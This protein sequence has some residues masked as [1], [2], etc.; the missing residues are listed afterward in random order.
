LQPRYRL[1]DLVPDKEQAVDASHR[2]DS[3]LSGANP[4]DALVE[5]PKGQSL[6]SPDTL[7][8]IAEVQSIV[9]SQ[10][11]I[12]NV[13]SLETLRRWLAK[14]AGGS[15]V[16]TLKQYVDLLPES[17][18]RRFISADQTAVV[19]SGRVA[20]LDASQLLP[21]IDSLNAALN[22]ARSKHPGYKISLTGLSVIAAQNSA[23]MIEKLNHGL[24]VEVLFVA[25]FIGLAFRSVIIS[26]AII[27]P[28]IFPILAAGDILWALGDGLQFASV[29]ALT[30]SF[31]LGLSAT[32]HFLNRLRLE[33]RPDAGPPS[34]SS[35]PRFLLVPL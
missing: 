34:A 10:P 18:V 24:M 31:G 9:E 32:I 17:L 8:T 20:D 5:I 27:L 4:I 29:V 23:A 7:A 6:Y 1:A 13:W 2:L 25:A 26:F 15:D 3:K 30:V 19:I 35:G 16:S 33:N 12:G 11:G 22:A 28:G 21:I 14:A